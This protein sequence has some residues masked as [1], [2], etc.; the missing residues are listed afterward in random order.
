MKKILWLTIGFMISS[1]NA[2]T[3]FYVTINNKTN[4]NA[5]ISHGGHDS[6][7]CNDFCGL[8]ILNA[9]ESK[10]FYTEAKFTN[11]DKLRING[12]AYSGIQGINIT[13]KDF[14]GHVEFWVNHRFNVDKNIKTAVLFAYLSADK[15]SGDHAIAG[16]GSNSDNITT[17]L[18]VTNKGYYSTAYI[19]LTL[20]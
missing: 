2:G 20:H 10:V 1:V 18:Y 12:S 9:K 17:Q 11:I 15:M 8:Q 3:G 19:T 13:Y 6:W 5:L 14:L 4:Y 16:V 7:Y